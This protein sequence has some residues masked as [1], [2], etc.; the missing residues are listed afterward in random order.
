MTQCEEC[1]YYA[2]DED[3]EAYM[4]EMNMDEDEYA[5]MVQGERRTNV[6]FDVA[7]PFDTKLESRAIKSYLEEKISACDER[8]C[9]II[10]IEHTL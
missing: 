3:Y 4:C 2:Y 5:R 1:Q 9:C 7:I 10:T 8:Y 6:L